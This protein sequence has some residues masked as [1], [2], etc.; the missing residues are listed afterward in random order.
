MLTGMTQTTND[1]RLLGVRVNLPII[2]NLT[3]RTDEIHM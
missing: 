1:P 3:L 2:K